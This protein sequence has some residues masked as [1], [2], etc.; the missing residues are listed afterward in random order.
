MYL[1]SKSKVNTICGDLITPHT[2][3][4][5]LVKLVVQPQCRVCSPNMCLTN[6]DRPPALDVTNLD[7]FLEEPLKALENIS[8]QGEKFSEVLAHME[9]HHVESGRFKD[10]AA[11]IKK[12]EGSS[13]PDYDWDFGKFVIQPETLAAIAA[14]GLFLVLL[15]C[16]VGH[17][18]C[19]PLLKFLQCCKACKDCCSTW[20]PVTGESLESSTA[21]E[22][23]IICHP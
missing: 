6:K 16:F 17:C 3:E 19:G 12:G 21:S 22:M 7:A 5:G 4:P 13:E 1:P 2:Y 10:I 18:S 11:N 20:S 14:S 8:F 15:S 23:P 9:D